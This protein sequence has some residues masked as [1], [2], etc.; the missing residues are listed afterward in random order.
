MKDLIPNIVYDEIEFIRESI[1]FSIN[2]NNGLH[3]LNQIRN[4]INKKRLSDKKIIFLSE[5]E[6]IDSAEYLNELYSLIDDY[7][8]NCM[9]VSATSSIYPYSCH[10]LTALTLWNSSISIRNHVSW[11]CNKSVDLFLVDKLRK[12]ISDN[13]KTNKGILSCR[14]KTI[15]RDKL[16]SNLKECNTIITRYAKWKGHGGAETENDKF[17]QFEFPSHG[18]IYDEYNSSIFSFVVESENGNTFTPTT[19]LTEKTLM[20]FLTGTMPIILGSPYYLKE[21]KHMGLTTWNHLFNFDDSLPSLSTK[22]VKSYINCIESID[23]LSL[24][25]CQY[26]WHKNKDIIQKNF[27]IVYELV[28]NEKNKMDKDL[29]YPQ[30]N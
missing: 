3:E 7:D 19:N 4:I 18:E 17:K 22:K 14:K 1:A 21:L 13:K 30:T 5:Q 24:E 15:R 27:D 28:I 12:N 11:N 10:P 23:N 29:I 16:F 6:N 26:L 25:D 2:S 20:A 8:L 9:I